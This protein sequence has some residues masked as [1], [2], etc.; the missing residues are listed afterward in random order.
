V[1]S[2]INLSDHVNLEAYF[3]PHLKDAARKGDE[4]S[5]RCP[6]PGHEDENSSFGVNL[7]TGQ[8][9]CFGCGR[10]GNIVTFHAELHGMTTKE[11]YWALVN[12]YIP[13]AT[14]KAS[15]GQGRQ[16]CAVSR[17][18][19][20][21]Q[22]PPGPAAG[23]RRPPR[24]LP[25]VSDLPLKPIPEG[26]KSWLQKKRGWSQETIS[27]YRVGY[28]QDEERFTIPILDE[29]GEVVNIRRYRPG[30]L[31]G[32]M[33]PWEKGTGQTRLYPLSS[34]EEANARACRTIVLC[35]G[36]PDALCGLSHGLVCI[37]QTAG[38][39]TWND[40]WNP[41][42]RGLNVLIAYDQDEAGRKGAERVVKHLPGFAA[43]VELVQWPE[44]M[45]EKQDLTDWFVTHLKTAAELLALPRKHIE[46]TTDDQGAVHAGGKEKLNH[47][48]AAEAT[49][50]EFGDGNLVTTKGVTYFWNGCGVWKELESATAKKKILDKFGIVH[51]TTKN[52][53]ESILDH[54]RTITTRADHS[55]EQDRRA[56]NC[57]NGELAW[58]GSRWVL[59]PHA[60]DKYRLTQVHAKFDPK[61][62]A[63][64]FKSYLDEIFEP[65]EDREEKKALVLEAIG[66]SL[67]PTTDFEKFFLLIGEGANGKSVLLHVLEHLVG[68]ENSVAVQPSQFDNRFQRAHLAGKL[69]NIVT[70]IAEGHEIADAQIKAIVSGEL[71]TAEKKHR[72]PFDFRPFCTCWFGTNHL[73]HSRD[74]S[75][76]FFRR[77]CVVTFNRYFN[78]Q[79]REDGLKHRLVR[80]ELDGILYLA[81]QAFG[82]V[83]KRGFFTE[84]RSS[85][86]A[87]DD[88]RL[89]CDQVQQF[90]QEWC[91][92]DPWE[93][94][95]SSELF[96]KYS[97]WAKDTGIKKTVAQ[98]SF[99]QRLMRLGARRGRVR[100]GHMVMHGIRIKTIEEK[101]IETKENF[102]DEE[103][104]KL[105]F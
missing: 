10:A 102:Q 41:L 87:K 32:K 71:T 62:K 65:D 2:A 40:E 25:S 3:L 47:L 51:N 76:A 35:E 50:H 13:G 82:E 18:H 55:W 26:I 85:S 75:T 42:F 9:K 77:A 64:R 100:T 68:L 48:A 29:A 99:G 60:R 19:V 95:R 73:P 101:A 5:G 34:L 89:N 78:E 52:T 7:V 88:W 63:E 54:V 104:S 27:K 83:L 58:D 103:N 45:V 57:R 56:I 15:G 69:V 92:F 93:H 8:Y 46:A 28:L 16:P 90:V 21:Q 39:E 79:E 24:P 49:V 20:G 80:E 86:E 23:S 98:R 97:D 72:A 94:E 36:E 37:T 105:P 14:G 33:L 70:E 4:L 44:F 91:V 38:A 31:K 61:A 30:L 12:Q 6:F 11:A 74:F 22:P 67:L 66:Y 43:R 81:V 59:A 53:V 17:G 1:P 84:V 96:Q